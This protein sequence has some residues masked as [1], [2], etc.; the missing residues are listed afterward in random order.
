MEL[1][2]EIESSAVEER[3]G[4]IKNGD[5]KGEAWRIRSQTGWLYNGSK[6]PVEI[7]IPLRDDQGAYGPGDY[8][9][10]PESFESGEFHRL[11]FARQLVLV[12]LV[13]AKQVRAA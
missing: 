13:A 7:S 2:I 4:T 11:Q 3:S 1:K 6:Y 5:R 12:P 10:A 8:T 9:I